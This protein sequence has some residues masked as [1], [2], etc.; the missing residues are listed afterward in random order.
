[1]KLY[2]AHL[3]RNVNKDH[4]QEIFSVYG[5]VKTVDLPTDRT[6]NLSRGFAYVEYV[7]PEECEKA[8]KHM[9]GG[10]IDGQEIAVQSVL[11]PR[12]RDVR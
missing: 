11:P 9:D 12:P 2:V 3:T 6:N 1:T 4:V 10:Q 8:L 7:D 5:R